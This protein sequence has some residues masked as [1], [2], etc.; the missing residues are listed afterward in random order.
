MLSPG[1]ANSRM[2]G[3][4]VDSTYFCSPQ[5]LTGAQIVGTLCLVISFPVSLS[6]LSWTDER[7]CLGFGDCGI[8][9]ESLSY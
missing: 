3:E 4:L 8:N 2:R 6:L 9:G 7:Q 1:P 5:G